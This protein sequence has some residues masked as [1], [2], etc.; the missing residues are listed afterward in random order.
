MAVR[1]IRPMP[2]SLEDREVRPLTA[3]EVLRMVDAGILPPSERVELLHGAL[4]AMS[5]KSPEHVT[6]K[7]RVIAWLEVPTHNVRVED[8]LLVPDRTSLP[9]PDVAVVARGDY[10]HVHPSS[11]LLVVE[12]AVSSRRIDLVV[13]PP[14]YAAAGIPDYWVVDVPAR[15]V[16]VFRDPAGDTYE[17]QLTAR[18]GDTLGPSALDVPPLDVTELLSGL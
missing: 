18:P 5:P 13:K 4:T 17:T 3:D 14:L 16:R 2:F 1:T 6:V 8:P 9:E 10:L 11:A 12:I 15:C 7:G